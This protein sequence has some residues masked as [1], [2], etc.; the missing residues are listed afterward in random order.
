[1]KYAPTLRGFVVGV[2]LF[3]MVGVTW[4]CFGRPDIG[5]IRID[6][7]TG[8]ELV[9]NFKD[10]PFSVKEL[11]DAGMSEDAARKLLGPPKPGSPD[12]VGPI[13]PSTDPTFKEGK[14]AAKQDFNRTVSWATSIALWI[15]IPLAIIVALASFV[16]PWIPTKAAI[17]CAASACAVVGIRYALL[18][19]GTIAVDWAVYI[20]AA[21][22]I[23]VVLV[24]GLPMAIAWV[25]RNTWKRAVTLAAEG[26]HID[27]AV[28]LAASVDPVIDKQRSDVKVWL[29]TVHNE[30]PADLPL[31]DKLWD[32]WRE[33]RMQLVKLGVLKPGDK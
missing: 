2:A 8:S 30:P 11:V 16:V 7:E 13:D 27:G 29:D 22:A 19:F 9:E 3:C 17:Y 26:E 15:F 12:F 32:K 23:V 21:S 25:K 18:T 6:P 10:K 5:R 31:N 20:S 1:M 4:G 24:V 33:A 14:A 28:A